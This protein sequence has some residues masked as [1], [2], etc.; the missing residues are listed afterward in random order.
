M[1]V[2]LTKDPQPGSSGT[3]EPG[4]PTNSSFVAASYNPRDYQPAHPDD[5][6]GK[7]AKKGGKGTAKAKGK[8]KDGT[9]RCGNC[10]A[11]DAKSKCMRCCVEHY[12]GKE[13]QAVRAG[14]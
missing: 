8:G 3:K 10:D 14:G 6:D 1:T 11:P 12:C 5:R 13:C 9:H 2:F 7:P 4:P